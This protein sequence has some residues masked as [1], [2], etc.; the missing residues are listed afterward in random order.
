MR[1]ELQA[2]LLRVIEERKIH[3]LG[4]SCEVPVDVRVLAAT[5]A[6]WRSASETRQS[7]PLSNRF[8]L[9]ATSRFPLGMIILGVIDRQKLILVFI[10]K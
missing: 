3:R 9:D 8:K 2:K 10:T 7:P 6:T 5:I 4:G 1:P